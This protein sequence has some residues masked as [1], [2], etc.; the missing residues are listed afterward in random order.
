VPIRLVRLVGCVKS[1]ACRKAANKISEQGRN[2][3]PVPLIVEADL[4]TQRHTER[5]DEQVHDRM[6]KAHREKKAKIGSQQPRI[7]PVIEVD[8]LP[9]II[10]RQTIQLQRIA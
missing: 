6:L 10:P 2:F 7:L 1:K 8:E 4:G 9:R 5:D 3:V